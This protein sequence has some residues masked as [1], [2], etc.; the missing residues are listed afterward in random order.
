MPNTELKFFEKERTAA[1]PEQIEAA[2]DIYAS[3]DIEIDDDAL[4]SNGP[5]D[6]GYW[7]QAWVWVG[8]A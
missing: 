2:R 1:S 5:E 3:D 4:L 7:V 8:V 6:S